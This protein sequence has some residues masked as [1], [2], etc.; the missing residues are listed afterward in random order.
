[1]KTEAAVLWEAGSD[2]EIE[3]VELDPPKS[4]EVLVRLW[5]NGLCHSDEHLRSGD[6]HCQLPIIGGHEGAGVVEEVGSHVTSVSPG[7]HVVLSWI[8]S[9]GKC[10][11]CATGHQNLCEFGQYITVGRQIQDQTARHHIGHH[12]VN[13]MACVGGFSKATV[14]HDSSVV[15][16]DDDIPLDRAC[17]VGCGVVTGWGSAVYAAQVAAGDDIAIIGFGGVGASALLGAIHAGARRV[18]VVDP[19]EYKREE[20]KRLGATHVAG[21]LVEAYELV[22][23]VTWGRMCAKAISCVGVGSG[24]LVADTMALVGKNGRVVVTNMHPRHEIDVKLR[25]AELTVMQ[26]QLVGALYGQGN[27]RAD[28]PKLLVRAVSRWAPRPRRTGDSY[29]P[30]GGDQRGFRGHA[31][32]AEPTRRAGVPV[33]YSTLQ[34]R[35]FDQ[36]LRRIYNSSPPPS[37]V[38]SQL[39]IRLGRT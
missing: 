24:A 32:R 29:L 3:P 33:R 22:A 12:D 36:A 38:W 34:G 17:L 31:Q 8:P 30:L 11:P 9:C 6:M 28:V 19:V 1:M 25:M 13:L 10:R 16:I 26:K 14:V 2:W 37:R 39:T 21:D 27:P 20:A 35:C 5:A 18:F 15:K 23:E 7:D 4:Q